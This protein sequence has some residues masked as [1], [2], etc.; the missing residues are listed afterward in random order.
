MNSKYAIE[1]DNLMLFIKS[2]QYDTDKIEDQDLKTIAIGI[3]EAL[4][5]EKI[6]SAGKTL[7]CRKSYFRIFSKLLFK[8]YI[9]WISKYC[10][11]NL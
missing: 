4:R 5:H 6:L 10:A 3:E 9:K 7:Y 8:E 2:L 1:F 11:A